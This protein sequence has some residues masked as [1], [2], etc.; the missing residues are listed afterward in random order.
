MNPTLKPSNGI[1]N[2]LGLFSLFFGVISMFFFP[3]LL[4]IPQIVAIVLGILGINVAKKNVGVSKWQSY[5]GLVLGIIYSLMLVIT[6][7]GVKYQ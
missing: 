1:R 5:A 3:L 7:L 6:M 2:N 4:G